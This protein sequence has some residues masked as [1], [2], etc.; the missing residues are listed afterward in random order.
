MSTQPNPFSQPTLP[1]DRTP[2]QRSAPAEGTP[3]ANLWMQSLTLH[4]PVIGLG[5]GLAAGLCLLMG[6]SLRILLSPDMHGTQNA[7]EPINQPDQAVVSPP[8]EP[9]ASGLPQTNDTAVRIVVPA[10]KSFQRTTA[11]QGV[12]QSS[13][14]ASTIALI[15]GG[16]GLA[17]GGMGFWGLRWIRRSFSPG[18]S[19][20][21]SDASSSAGLTGASLAGASSSSA[22]VKH[23]N[24]SSA[25]TPQASPR[26]DPL[27]PEILQPQRLEP[28][29]LEPQRLE[30]QRLEPHAIL[31]PYFP[32]P[33]QALDPSV[34]TITYWAGPNSDLTDASVMDPDLPDPT[35]MDSLET[36][37]LQ[38]IQESLPPESRSQEA[39]PQ[40]PP[41]DLAHLMDIRKRRPHS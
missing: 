25:L 15:L 23:P 41:T 20:I 12:N 6:I 39:I 36:P 21:V 17:L 4:A 19:G 22:I 8:A 33:P 13:N 27:E 26:L 31:Q 34:L 14:K 16:G 40:E 11:D 9:T 10:A 2:K 7:V 28:Q 30:S 32:T 29:R 3:T 24:P 5:F 1:Q 18:S 38:R 37:P 35:L